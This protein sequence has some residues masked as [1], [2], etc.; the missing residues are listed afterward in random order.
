[1][2]IP[3]PLPPTDRENEKLLFSSKYMT[4]DAKCETPTVRQRAFG[5]RQRSFG[6]HTSTDRLGAK[7]VRSQPLELRLRVLFLAQVL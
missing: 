4:L 1:M 6:T 5:I 3:P 7:T 2:R